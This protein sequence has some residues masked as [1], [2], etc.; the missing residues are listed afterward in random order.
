M[1][2]LFFISVMGHGR[3]GHFHSL[4][5]IAEALSEHVD[6]QI[7]SVGPGKSDIIHNHKSFYAHIDTTKINFFQF[8]KKIREILKKEN[9]DVIHCF[10][11][12]TFNLLRLAL[13]PH[14]T[15]M[16]VNLCGGPNPRFFPKVS[17]LVLFSEENKQWFQE[18]RKFKNT[19]IS[20]IPNRVNKKKYLETS[21]KSHS[22][23]KA[24][25]K[26]TLMRISRIGNTYKKSIDDSIRLVKELKA[27]G[28]ENILLYIIGTIEDQQV[29]ES[30]I[31]ETEGLPIQFL[32]EDVYTYKASDMLYFTDAVIATG[33]GIMEATALGKPV[34]APAHNSKFP[35]L[36]QE[37]NYYDFFKVNFSERSMAT[38]KSM[39]ENMDQ[40]IRMIRNSDDYKKS[41]AFSMSL[42]S[43]KFDVKE[44]CKEYLKIYN[45]ISSYK[46]RYGVFDDV[47]NQAYYFL[48]FFRKK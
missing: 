31:A 25:D 46:I 34:L 4:N 15:R 17:H 33:R 48:K 32:T 7:I 16:V 43:E 21:P 5:H 29:Y 8:R 45:N 38:D 24:P 6:A 23:E 11:S 41:A 30:L 2:V 36:L 26:F 13:Y 19:A 3:G 14:K 35:I 10:D 42:F 18:R 22:L 44:G 9:P 39:N 47:L 27:R 40:I 37:D 12:N 1:K 28:V 20:L